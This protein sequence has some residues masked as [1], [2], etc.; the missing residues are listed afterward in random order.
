[1]LL[2]IFNTFAIIIFYFYLSLFILNYP[3]ISNINGPTA[4]MLFLFALSYLFNKKA[5]SKSYFLKTLNSIANSREKIF[6][7]SAIIII[8]IVLSALSIARH[9]ALSSGTSDLGIFDQAIWN[10]LQGDI[11]F[12][13]LKGN[14]N[15]LGD[16]FEPILLLITPL[17][18]AWPSPIVLLILQASLLALAI[19][20]LYLI[21]KEILKERILIF[22]FVISYILSRPLRGV[23]LSDFHPEC[24]IL[25]LLFWAYYFLIKRKN[26]LLFLS[27][28][29]LLLCKEDVAFLVAGFGLFT[30]FFQKRTGLGLVLFIL[31]ISAWFIE[32]KYIIPSFNPSGIYPYMNRLPFG[33]T[34]MDN[35]KAVFANPALLGNIFFTGDKIEYV[36]KIF[37]PLAFLPSL[38]PA[39]YILIAVPLLRN[40]LPTDVNFSGWYNITSH[41]TAAVI[42]F[43]FIAA[44]Y[45]VRRL[46]GRFNNKNAAKIIGAVIIISALFFYGKTDAHKF[47]R[48]IK[49]IREGRT[50]ERV[51]YLKQVPPDASI[52]TNFNLVP[53]ASHRKYVF[54]W[55]PHAQTSFIAEY[56]AI[57]MNLL[58]YLSEDDRT[59]IKPYLDKI[60]DKGYRRVFLNEDKTFLIMH[61]P[62][63]KTPVIK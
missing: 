10:T 15:L 6:V 17:Y 2:G 19:I 28:S 25:F 29:L 31:G 30:V 42:P 33:L 24:F 36:L 44:I 43:V 39:H 57:D 50:L 49:T 32:T 21:S 16:H 7:I 13:S 37:G 61:N 46:I 62:D 59:K 35:F 1:M 40:L 52:S 23:G 5:P 53:H 22:S 9:F 48:F 3:S 60:A 11:L 51:S 20:P 26:A 4:G 34:Y 18:R 63:A 12:S 58:E 55:N 41:Y 8:F 56:I 38:S 45:G 47:W 54:E 14:I 27:I